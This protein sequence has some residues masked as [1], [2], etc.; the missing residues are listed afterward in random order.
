MEPTQQPL[1]FDTQG[2]LII[3]G[4]HSDNYVTGVSGWTINKDGSAE[5]NNVVIR[6][7]E[8]L[9][10]TALYYSGTP[11]AGNLVASISG[12]A[13]TDPFG[14]GYLA[15]V[16][17]YDPVGFTFANMQGGEFQIGRMVTGNIPDTTQSTQMT[18]YP[19][20]FNITGPRDHD[21]GFDDRIFYQMLAGETIVPTLNTTEPRIQFFDTTNNAGVSMV[22][23]GAVIKSDIGGIAETWQAAGPMAANW[24]NVNFRYR[25]GHENDL[26]I[27]GLLAYS[28]AAVNAANAATILTTPIP[29]KYR[30]ASQVRIPMNHF[31]STGVLKNVSANLTI[32]TA[33]VMS[34]LWGDGVAG[35][36]HDVN[37]LEVND[38]FEIYTRVSLGTMA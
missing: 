25:L 28:G 30:P 24:N 2:N 15:G 6:G 22:L 12:A 29:A 14:N 8:V 38:R 17:V 20:A 26:L 4:V 5:F 23:S 9:G 34:V 32:S 27:E 33:G 35:T 13:G 21:N 37:G 18:S 1:A 3:P 7:S 31:T 10:G 19:G 36:A 11:A 16:S